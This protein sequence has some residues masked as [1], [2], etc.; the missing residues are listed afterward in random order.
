MYVTRRAPASGKP[1]GG[2]IPTWTLICQVSASDLLQTYSHG[3][4]LFLLIHFMV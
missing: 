3:S 1:A 2:K 4:K